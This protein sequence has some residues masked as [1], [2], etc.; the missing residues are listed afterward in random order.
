MRATPISPMP[1]FF[2]QVE[3]TENTP[4]DVRVERLVFCVS[5]EIVQG[6]RLARRL[7]FFLGMPSGEDRYSS[8]V[9]RGYSATCRLQTR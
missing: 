4:K 5:L 3:L 8:P 2:L 1:I 6:I 9:T 7:G